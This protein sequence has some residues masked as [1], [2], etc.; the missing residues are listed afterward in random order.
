GALETLYLIVVILLTFSNIMVPTLAL[1]LVDSLF[2]IPCYIIGI[3][4]PAFFIYWDYLGK[5]FGDCPSLV[6]IPDEECRTLWHTLGA[7]QLLAM[8]LQF[9]G[10]VLTIIDLVRV[11]RIHRDLK[12]KASNEVK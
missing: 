5:V 2:L 10:L 8:V 9:F 6:P 11:I 4:L 7:L 3:I 1:I 12:N